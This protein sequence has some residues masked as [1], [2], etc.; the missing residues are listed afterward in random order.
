M[1]TILP[2][3]CFNIVGN[4]AAAEEHGFEVH[5]DDIVPIGFGHLHHRLAI[6]AAGDVD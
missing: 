4:T 5:I 3:F 1:L 2:C 6:G